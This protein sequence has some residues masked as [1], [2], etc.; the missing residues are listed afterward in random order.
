MW[1]YRNR[2]VTFE[3]KPIEGVLIIM[4]LLLC[5][6]QSNLLYVGGRPSTRLFRFK[7]DISNLFISSA[8]LSLD[9]IVTLHNQAF[10]SGG[11]INPVSLVETSVRYCFPS[12]QRYEDCY[13]P[14]SEDKN[15][16]YWVLAKWTIFHL[17]SILKM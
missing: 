11:T 14:N 17:N 16:R 8:P 4:P 5:F 3:L 2:T 9:T 7:G 10:S 6:P 12:V 13:V 15:F 1:M